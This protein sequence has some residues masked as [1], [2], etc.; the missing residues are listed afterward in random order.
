MGGA[1]AVDL[2]AFREGVASLAEEVGRTADS[3]DSDRSERQVARW[4][5]TP[6][7]RRLMPCVPGGLEMIAHALIE[8]L[9]R[10][11]RHNQR[12]SVTTPPSVVVR[13]YLLS[14][15]DSLWWDDAPQFETDRDIAQSPELAEAHELRR[16]GL[17]HFTYHRLP[18]GLPGR[19]LDWARRKIAPSRRPRT[20]G[21]RLT[22]VRPEVLVLLNQL[23]HEFASLAPRGTPSMWV[24]SM[25][26]S[27]QEQRELRA[28]GYPAFLPSAHCSG[29]AFDVEVEWFRRFGAYDAITEL[30]RERER[31]GDI[32]AIDE[33]QVWHVCMSPQAVTEA[34]AAGAFPGSRP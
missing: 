28:L 27:V 5:A 19:G 32:N 7:V 33:G 12:F 30:L 2:T 21:L 18:R 1:V 14:R 25:M 8:E 16:S 3:F 9:H 31:A 23:A 20:A 34:R 24:T 4:L 6:E 17:L 11:R 29:Y 10:F 26:R 13:S 15:I 22:A